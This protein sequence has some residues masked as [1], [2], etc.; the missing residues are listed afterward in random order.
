MA[1]QYLTKKP[2]NT[3]FVIQKVGDKQGLAID[4]YFYFYFSKTPFMR[5]MAIGQ[6][7]RYPAR[8]TTH[9]KKI[10]PDTRCPDSQVYLRG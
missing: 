6:Q 3:N 7:Q 2:Q 1:A 9:E 5:S 10:P 8:T 4:W